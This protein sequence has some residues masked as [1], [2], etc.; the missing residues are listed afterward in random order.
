MKS[1]SWFIIV[2]LLTATLV[3]AGCVVVTPAVPAAEAPAAEAPA[4][5]PVTISIWH[6]YIETEEET[7]S[8]AVAG[9]LAANPTIKIDVLAVPFDELQSIQIGPPSLFLS[10]ILNYE[11]PGR[12]EMVYLPLIYGL[13]WFTEESILQDGSFTHFMFSFKGISMG[14]GLGQQDLLI[15]EGL[16]GLASI[17]SIEFA[18]DMRAQDFEERCR[19]RGLD[20]SD[21][22][23]M[24]ETNRKR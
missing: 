1:Y 20:P 22:R 9:F 19:N 24:Y 2:M 12:S 10:A 7:F 5:E 8:Q 17:E 18:L 11:A 13:S 6:G 4:E 23:R 21:V 15:N 14:V 16:I 3:L